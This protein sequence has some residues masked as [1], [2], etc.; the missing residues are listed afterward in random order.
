MHSIGKV[1]GNFLDI[2]TRLTRC[3]L[4][5]TT[6]GTAFASPPELQPPGVVLGVC[7]LIDYVLVPSSKDGMSDYRQNKANFPY[8]KGAVTTL[9]A[10]CSDDPL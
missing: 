8:P 6:P 9:V 7:W 10:G 3:S 4:S 1:F 2:I 5:F